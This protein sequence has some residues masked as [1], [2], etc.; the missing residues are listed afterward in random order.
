MKSWV[1]NILLVVAVC[2]AVYFFTIKFSHPTDEDK[3]KM[4]L[5][6]IDTCLAPG[7]HITFKTDAPDADL[8]MLYI[9][10]FLGPVKLERPVADKNDTMFLLLRADMTD[11]A[12]VALLRR[13]VIL[14]VN[15]D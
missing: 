11:T 10:Y 13:S 8:N 15:K 1:I 12:I 5:A 14:W 6:G 3:L 7:S 9:N 2:C 4:G